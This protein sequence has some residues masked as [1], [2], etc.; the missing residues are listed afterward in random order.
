MHRS[1]GDGPLPRSAPT[2]GGA[3]PPT[4]TAVQPHSA[5]PRSSS[6]GA[7]AL[8]PRAPAMANGAL[9]PTSGYYAS[10][11][12]GLSVPT[13]ARTFGRSSMTPAMP[14]RTS[15]TPTLGRSAV[16]Q[17]APLAQNSPRYVP[18]RA[19]APS[20]PDPPPPRADGA[21]R[22]E[23][24]PPYAQNPDKP[25]ERIHVTSAKRPSS[26]GVAERPTAA[27][28]T[29][30]SQPTPAAP[31]ARKTNAPAAGAGQQAPVHRP[32]GLGS[33]LAPTAQRS[34][35]PQAYIRPRQFA[36]PPQGAPT[37]SPRPSSATA[38]LRV[39]NSCPAPGNSPRLSL[40]SGAGSPRLSLAKPST[41]VTRV[42]SS[43]GQGPS[44]PA[45]QSSPRTISP[46][47]P[48]PHRSVTFAP[49]MATT[50]PPPVFP[51]PN[52]ASP[53]RPTAA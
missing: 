13:S 9:P 15:A 46:A 11:P 43:P 4:Y 22:V 53:N 10:R 33:A 25:P 30:A 24:P 42:T 44:S 1:A 51:I 21:A 27:V 2:P 12:N 36:S 26:A 17:R 7:G 50:P 20:H 18:I 6:V 16:V 48:P 14:T 29:P 47:T 40:V 32:V 5:R 49:Q 37:P 41:P 31:V 52:V 19:E 35:T 34:L 28:R 39:P 45:Y 23:A 38:T 8:S 3:K